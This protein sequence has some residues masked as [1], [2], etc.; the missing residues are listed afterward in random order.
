MHHGYLEGMAGN[1][2]SYRLVV[3]GSLED[4]TA[5]ATERPS[6][7]GRKVFATDLANG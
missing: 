4:A 3:G 2:A 1:N 7:A 6:D 5:I